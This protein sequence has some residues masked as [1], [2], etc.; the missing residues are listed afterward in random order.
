MQDG[1]QAYICTNKAIERCRH[2]GYYRHRQE[3]PPV[4]ISERFF[5]MWL[6]VTQGNPEQKRKAKWLSIFL[7]TWY[8][9]KELGQLANEHIANLTAKNVGYDKALVFTKAFTQSK[10][11]T[12]AQRDS[13]L[14]LTTA[15]KPD[16]TGIA[17]LELPEKFNTILIEISNLVE[18]QKFEE[19]LA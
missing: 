10:Y 16:G 18:Q 14:D 7:E 4:Q 5:N 3:K 11:I 19:A 9:G 6:I 17:L 13:L 15:L 8:D 2:N 1:E 12:T